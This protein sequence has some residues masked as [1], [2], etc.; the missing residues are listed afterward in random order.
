MKKIFVVSTT[1]TKSL[2][3]VGKFRNNH[4]EFIQKYIDAW[5]LI[6]GGRQN[7]H[8]GGLILSYNVTKY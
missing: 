7:P 3:E 4:F 2:E 5:K 1:Y 6:A 8:T